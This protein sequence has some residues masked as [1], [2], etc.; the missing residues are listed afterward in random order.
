MVG[1]AGFELATPC[2]PCKCATRL[3]YTPTSLA[4][5]PAG[6]ARPLWMRVQRAKDSVRRRKKV[7]NLEEFAPNERK[8]LRNDVAFGRRGAVLEVGKAAVFHLDHFD[9][10]EHHFAGAALVALDLHDFLQL[11]ARAADGEALVVEQVADAADHEHLV[12]LVVAPVAAALHRTQLRE[13]L[14]PIP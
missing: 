4:L 13:L 14:L 9:A 7:A 5:Y 1:V 8:L 11:V 3:R 6:S 12:V 2:T 10:F